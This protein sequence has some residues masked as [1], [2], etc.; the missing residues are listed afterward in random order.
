MPAVGR[1]RG[2]PTT[3]KELPAGGRHYLRALRLQPFA[4]APGRLALGAQ[5]EKAEAAWMELLE[6]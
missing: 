4:E 1:Q 3:I 2:A 5:L 6:S